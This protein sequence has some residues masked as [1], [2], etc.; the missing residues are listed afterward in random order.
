MYNIIKF[1]ELQLCL[2]F[3]AFVCFIMHESNAL[4][5]L[6]I[7]K[8]TLIWGDTV[9]LGWVKIKSTDFYLAHH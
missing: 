6:P 3:V 1:M 7:D 5:E 4:R 2:N 9:A 8:V